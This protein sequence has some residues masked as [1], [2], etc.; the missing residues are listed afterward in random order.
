MAYSNIKIKAELKKRLEQELGAGKGSGLAFSD[1]IEMLLDNY[2]SAKNA[3]KKTEASGRVVYTASKY[4][5]IKLFVDA[6][7]RHNA[8]AVKS[9]SPETPI[10]IG[11]AYF[12][13]RETGL[14]SNRDVQPHWEEIEEDLFKH[15]K[16]YR[17]RPSNNKQEL[18]HARNDKKQ[19]KYVAKVLKN[20][21]IAELFGREND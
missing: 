16:R 18:M 15:N 17:I 10:Y 1:A 3:G 9:N 4:E 14:N 11:S 12:I 19:H 21:G 5:R 6:I 20:E 13:A 7:K 2:T 8:S